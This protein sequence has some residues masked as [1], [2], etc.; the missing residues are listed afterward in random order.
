[1]NNKKFCCE[2]LEGAYSVQ[3]GFGLNFR[4]VKF[5]EPLYSKLKLINPNMLDKGFVMTSG[6]IHTIND[7]KTKSLFINN[8]PFCGQKLSDFY[9]SDDYVQEIIKD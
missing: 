2:R 1:M 4:I 6:Y 7:E 8:C 5:T 9:K 3:N